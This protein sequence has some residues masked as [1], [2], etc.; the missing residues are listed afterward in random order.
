[1]TKKS[2]DE[3][4]AR[5]GYQFKQD[6]WLTQALTH[7]SYSASHNERLEFLGD[8]V[9]GCVI[10]AYLY[11]QFPQMPEGDLSRLRSNL[12]REN[13][14]VILAKKLDLGRYLKLGAGEKRSGGHQRPSMLADAMEA[15]FGAVYQ[16]GGFEPAQQVI[17]HLFIPYINEIDLTALGKD[18]KTLLQ[19]LLQ[20]QRIPLPAYRVSQVTG[21]AHAQQFEVECL[22]ERLNIRTTGTG[23]SRRRAEQ[24]AAQ[25]AYQR[26]KERK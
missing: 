5:L 26:V 20:S 23:G 14:L 1:M 12:V 6:K 19:E 15:I 11:H 21:E 17:L 22:I 7:R 24:Q 25:A 10:A 18:A 4:S 3:L 9:L 2:N 8:S 16:D 13:T